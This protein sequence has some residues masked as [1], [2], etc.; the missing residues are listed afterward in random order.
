MRMLL[1]CFPLTYRNFIIFEQTVTLINHSPLLLMFHMLLHILFNIIKPRE[2]LMFAQTFTNSTLRPTLC[3]RPIQTHS[4]SRF[5]CF[6][7]T[8][9]PDSTRD[10]RHGNRSTLGTEDKLGTV[11]TVVECTGLV[12]TAAMVTGC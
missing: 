2:L 3:I 4:L 9:G 6:A 12:G 8:S 10:A 5:R 7:S 1:N 11:V